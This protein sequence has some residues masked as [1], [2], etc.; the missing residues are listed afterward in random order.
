MRAQPR[1]RLL[2][3][4]LERFPLVRS[5]RLHADRGGPAEAGHYGHYIVVKTALGAGAFRNVQNVARTDRRWAT[6]EKKLID[7]GKAHRRRDCDSHWLDG[8][9][10]ASTGD[11]GGRAIGIV[12]PG[13]LTSSAR[14]GPDKTDDA[15]RAERQQGDDDREHETPHAPH[16]SAHRLRGE[17]HPVIFAILEVT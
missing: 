17:L 8:L 1:I 10:T 5:V 7:G 16:C 12:P 2:W 13:R 11:A 14:F 15:R 4:K 9:D 6:R 3:E